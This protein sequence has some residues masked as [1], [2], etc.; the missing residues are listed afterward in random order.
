[1]K[2]VIGIDPGQETGFAIWDCTAKKLERVTSYTFWETIEELDIIKEECIYNGYQLRVVIEDP[3]QNKPTFKRN[4]MSKGEIDR[5]AQNVGMNKEHGRLLV[6]YC[7]R[8]G[9][10][11][12]KSK[13][14]KKSM[15]KL[16]AK[17]FENITGFKGRTNSHGRDAAM[18]VYQFS[19]P[20]FKNND[21]EQKHTIASP[22]SSGKGNQ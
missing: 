8:K 4:K 20:N 3:Y 15:T 14:T 13:P 11:V 5:R 1:M 18:L 6:Q 16:D 12:Y 21:S 17:Q 10:I 2:I 9:L 19:E 7:E 22:I